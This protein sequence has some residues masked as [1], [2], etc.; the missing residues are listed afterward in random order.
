MVHV[1]G[2][3]VLSQ[4]TSTA[5]QVNV[6]LWYAKLF[7]EHFAHRMVV[8]LT[9]VNQTVVY[10]ATRG[11]SRPYCIDDR[12]NLH[13]IRAC[14]S[15]YGYCFHYTMFQ[16]SSSPSFHITNIHQNAENPTIFIIQ[17]HPSLIIRIQCKR[18]DRK[19][20]QLL[21]ILFYDPPL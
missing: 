3:S 15:N 6:W 8:M 1:S 18:K 12:C 17:S 4:S 14:T 13:E 20:E 2:R 7:K 9:C 10:F 19:L 5:T 11:L 16:N 21:L